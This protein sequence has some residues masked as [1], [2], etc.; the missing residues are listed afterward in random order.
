[1]TGTPPH[2]N[3]AREATPTARIGSAEGKLDVESP[4][5]EERSASQRFTASL[6]A[7]GHVF[8]PARVGRRPNAFEERHTA[9]QLKRRV[10]DASD[11]GERFRRLRLRK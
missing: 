9:R 3:V 7:D 4:D 2:S 11:R 10:L 8:R 1:M 5:G 6:L